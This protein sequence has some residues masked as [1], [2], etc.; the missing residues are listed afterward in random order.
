MPVGTHWGETLM[1]AEND[2]TTLSP[3]AIGESPYINR[4]SVGG[5]LPQRW[6][7]V[8]VQ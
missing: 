5:E 7:K 6:V 8:V 4:V 2:P 1:A 3:A